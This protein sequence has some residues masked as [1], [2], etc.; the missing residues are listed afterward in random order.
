MRVSG[1][2]DYYGFND[3]KLTSKRRHWRK[4]L[5]Q[6]LESPAMPIGVTPENI[7]RWSRVSLTLKRQ[8]VAAGFGVALFAAAGSVTWPEGQDQAFFGEG[9]DV[10]LDGGVPYKDFWEIKGPLADYTYALA[11]YL[12]GRH[13]SAIRIFD[14]LVVAISC[15]LLRKIV[16]QLN[17]GESP[18]ANA[19]VVF[20]L[21][22]YYGLGYW[23]TA[24]PDGY[25]GFIILA[26]V[27]LLLSPPWKTHW[28]MTAVGVLSGSAVLFKPTFLAFILLPSL[29]P[30]ANVDTARARVSLAMFYVAVTVLTIAIELFLIFHAS[31]GFVDLWDTLRFL[32]TSYASVARLSPGDQ[33]WELLSKPFAMGFFGPLLLSPLILR[34]LLRL[35]MNYE[36]RVIGLWIC[37]SLLVVIIQGRYYEYHWLPLMISVSPIFG[38]AVSWSSQRW[39]SIA[40]SKSVSN[41]LILLLIAISLFHSEVRA[42]T[43]SYT[44]PAF[45]TGSLSHKDYTR[46]VFG[47]GWYADSQDIASYIDSHSNETDKVL[48]W[49]TDSTVHAL[50]KRQS[51]TRYEVSYPI[52]IPGPL[53]SKYKR[54]FLED[55]ARDPPRY[56][57]IDCRDPWFMT[58]KTG[59]EHLADFPAFESFLAHYYY[60]L[61]TF[62]GYE[63]WEIRK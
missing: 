29:C 50:A 22:T 61:E 46:Q 27:A 2:P 58:N 21:V 3:R 47:G 59:Y 52:V 63:L 10:I 25:A 62:G 38:L 32:S 60:H 54:I 7:S 30:T 36:L 57:I 45:A 23:M 6:I 19:A 24:Q 9:G 14:L 31:D 44:W 37:L 1:F 26:A 43:Q 8:L 16:L 55:V 18:G 41:S 28:T 15:L 40:S 48:M 35:G 4:S 56:V 20:F 17:R 42:I 34:T 39:P 13:A 51:P 11:R 33:I 49:G 5:H 53:A 12:F